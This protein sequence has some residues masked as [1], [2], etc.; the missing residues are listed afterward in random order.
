M[1]LAHGLSLHSP[2][3]RPLPCQ[4]VTITVASASLFGVS[5]HACA[6]LVWYLQLAKVNSFTGQIVDRMR[7]QLRELSMQAEKETAQARKD[8]LM[9]VGRHYAGTLHL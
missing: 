1:Y 4:Y 6:C 3:T 8:D 5:S 9:K 2:S 7:K